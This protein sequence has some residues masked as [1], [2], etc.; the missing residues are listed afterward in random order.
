MPLAGADR[1]AP[2]RQRSLAATVEWSYRLLGKREKRVF[3]AGSVFPG[4]F[5]L[6]A[7]E[8]VAG[9]G[10]GPAVLHLVDCSL[11]TPPT[12]GPDGRARYVMLE[13]LRAYGA[14]LLAGAGE[15]DQATAALAGWALETAEQAAAGLQTSTGEADAARRLDAEDATLRQVL[16]WAMGRDREAALRLAAALGGGWLL[17]GRLAGVYPLLAELAGY[18]E[19]GSDRWCICL[20]YTSPS[21]RDS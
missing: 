7:A 9:P 6:Q 2:D 5:T 17:R 20:L 16:A 19:P 15:Q 21:P 14:G 1:L 8:A 11:L 12:T 3:R 10:T 18:A 4:P 13:T